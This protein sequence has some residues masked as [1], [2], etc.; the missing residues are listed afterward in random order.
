MSDIVKGSIIVAAGLIISAFLFSGRYTMLIDS[1]AAEIW[2]LDR[3]TG[4][5]AVCGIPDEKKVAGC[6]PMKEVNGASVKSD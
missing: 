3:Y 2:R 6:A 1:G 5:I 4:Q